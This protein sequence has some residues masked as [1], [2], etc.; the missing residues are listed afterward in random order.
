MK[1][2]RVLLGLVAAVA[3]MMFLFCGD[4]IVKV[5]AGTGGGTQQT[6][7]DPAENGPDYDY[8]TMVVTQNPKKPGEFIL[9]YGLY[10]SAA[11]SKTG[12][13]AEVIAEIKNR[14]KAAPLY[15]QF[16]DGAPLDA[17]SATAEIAGIWQATQIV[18]KG[19]LKGGSATQS[20][21]KITT[22]TP[23]Y[24]DAKIVNAAGGVAIEIGPEADVGVNRTNNTGTI[25]GPVSNAPQFTITGVARTGAG[26][27]EVSLHVPAVNGFKVYFLVKNPTGNED[28]SSFG[29][30][31]DVTV[32]A[33]D[34]PVVS[35]NL[36]ATF[37]TAASHILVLLV[38]NDG[39][40]AIHSAALP[41]ERP[42]PSIFAFV[43][44]R[45]QAGP[46]PD[47]DVNV[48]FMFNVSS[49]A[50]TYYLL[51]EV[52]SSGT[53]TTTNVATIIANGVPVVNPQDNGQ[54]FAAEFITVKA[55]KSYQLAVAAK[56]D[57]DASKVS[58]SF[59]DL[60]ITGDAVAA[61]PTNGSATRTNTNQDEI[62][63][64]FTVAEKGTAYYFLQEVTLNTTNVPA[65]LP[66]KVKEDGTAISDVDPADNPITKANVTVDKTKDSYIN[67]V[68]EDTVDNLSTVLKFK[69][70][71]LD[72]TGP[73]LSGGD[74]TRDVGV[75]GKTVATLSF[76]SDE[77]VTSF[78]YQ[79]TTATPAN[80][81]A[82]VT[83]GTEV[84]TVTST[85]D[86]D[87]DVWTTSGTITVTAAATEVF[88]V[89]KDKYGN[90]S[91][92]LEDVTF[93]IYDETPPTLTGSAPKRFGTDAAEFKIKSTESGN[94]YYVVDI[95]N[96]LSSK[97]V[98]YIK[99]DGIKL[100]IESSD[101]NVDQLV[102]LDLTEFNAT[103]AAVTVYAVAEDANE[104]LTT[105]KQTIPIAAAVTF[106]AGPA[107]TDV[108]LDE[109]LVKI[110]F[111]SGLA[112]TA[113]VL[114]NSTATGVEIAD[115][116]D[117]Q[118]ITEIAAAAQ[119]G[120]E[121]TITGSGTEYI[122][123]VVE[124]AT[125]NVT[126]VASSAVA[127]PAAPTIFTTIGV[128]GVFDGTTS[129]EVF[130]LTLT[131]A[132]ASTGSAYY[133]VIETSAD[134]FTTAATVADVLG[135]TDVSSPVTIASGS[136]EVL[137]QSGSSVT[138]TTAPHKAYVVLM[139]AD[140][141]V[142]FYKLL[143]PVTNFDS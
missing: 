94:I 10:K 51:R 19:E 25:T 31:A 77:E 41:G 105:L 124:D 128:E 133:L 69:V 142:N 84:T 137:N 46:S 102:E 107:V 66:A 57:V 62:E 61:V 60:T 70:P 141:G 99:T 121:V 14:S 88:V 34:P 44:T 68:L 26:T 27:A 63:F 93:D 131:A 108:Y 55:K 15:I 22:K 1:H 50:T 120:K 78:I 122:H 126:N 110:S 89:G 29:T 28:K 73:V 127:V 16:G 111:T 134:D 139:I 116:L 95:D 104:N 47:F 9:G 3:A 86:P 35:H 42:V 101:A 119:T 136:N 5:P 91:A 87:D 40:Y 138:L 135:H 100:E 109:D 59:L 58:T 130:S 143:A 85:Y 4:N 114:V 72:L 53:L 12:T 33:S 11:F 117:G 83:A 2:N 52:P 129:N 113:Y 103:A 21:L 37:S 64:E 7:Q 20:A 118:S 45:S 96:S 6:P 75:T 92:A 56:D 49:G 125:G 43:S 112:G 132:L 74:V 18:Y 81:A 38:D 8:E 79:V 23:G 82:L 90:V 76:E 32:P 97:S 13:L 36:S 140:N 17:G 106:S 115:V 30:T 67:I 65:I 123:V 80:A 98:D 48:A 39:N 24:V 54:G 71:A